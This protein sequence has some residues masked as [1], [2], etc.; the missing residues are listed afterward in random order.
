MTGYQTRQFSKKR[1]TLLTVAVVGAIA[2]SMLLVNF[3]LFSG[4]TRD[5]PG[6][7]GSTGES[8]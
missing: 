4:F 6:D 8:R 7:G 3:D 1:T 5:K 2:A